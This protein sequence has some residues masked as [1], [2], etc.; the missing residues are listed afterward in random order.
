VQARPILA[1]LQAYLRE[2]RAIGVTEEGYPLRNS[3]A[4][5]RCA[6]DGP[7]KIDNNQS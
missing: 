2:Q 7:L 1:K 4:L 3:V 5:T 6:E